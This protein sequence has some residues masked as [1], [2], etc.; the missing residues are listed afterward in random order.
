MEVVKDDASH[1][2]KGYGAGESQW[3]DTAA[4][5]GNIWIQLSDANR[6]TNLAVDD[7][8]KLVF[9]VSKQMFG[10]GSGG[11]NGGENSH[12]D[13]NAFVEFLWNYEVVATVHASD[14][15]DFNQFY[16]FESKVLHGNDAFEFDQLMIR[17]G[18]TETTAQGLAIDHVVLDWWI[19]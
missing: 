2:I 7:E 14:L 16:Q 15:D 10:D 6:T 18:G 9:S 11:S 3:L 13:P 12:T 17:S 19:A 4:S 8:A 1:L 5:P